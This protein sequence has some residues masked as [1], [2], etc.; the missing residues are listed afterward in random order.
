MTKGSTFLTAAA[1]ALG[2]ALSAAS[3]QALTSNRLTYLTFSGA[4]AL[5]GVTLPAGSYAFEL[6]DSAGTNNIV[7]VRN[8]ERSKVYFL[9]FTNRIARPAA[10]R[11]ISAVSFGE[12]A[13]GQP[14]PIAVWY[15]PES[16]DGLQFRYR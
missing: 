8:R 16:S 14:R 6:A 5:P 15:P 1:V 10:M 7:L 13:P 12:A 11:E 9:G 4:V 2:L 3:V